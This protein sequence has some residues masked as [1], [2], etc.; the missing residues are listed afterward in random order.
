MTSTGIEINANVI[1]H[2]IDSSSSVILKISWNEEHVVSYAFSRWL[3][4]RL[5]L[6]QNMVQFLKD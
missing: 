2:T 4:E 3:C 5:E 1:E 6:L